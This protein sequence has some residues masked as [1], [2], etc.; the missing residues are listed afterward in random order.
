MK[1]SLTTRLSI[2]L[3]ILILASFACQT[4][5]NS[6]SR[7]TSTS[8]LGPVSTQTATST[9]EAVETQLPVQIDQPQP[10]PTLMALDLD[11]QMEI[12]EE[13]WTTVNQEYLYPDFN[14]V[15]WDEVYQRYK[16]IVESGL[17]TETFYITMDEMIWELNDEHS[18]Y[19]NPQRVAEEE[20]EYAGN[21][22]YVGIGIWVQFDPDKD[23]AVVLLT[24]P[25]SPAEAAGVKSHDVILSVEGV[26]FDD[27]EGAALDLMLGQPGTQVT[28][29]IQTPGESPREMTV[30]RA[31]ITSSIPV[32]YEALTTPG[33]RRVGYILIPTFSDSTID[34]QVGEALAA[35]TADQPLDGIILDNR[36][37]GGGWENVAAN[38]LGYFTSGVVGHFSNRAGSEPFKVPRKNVGGSADLPLVVLVGPDTVS[39]GEIV[40][41]VLKDQGR[42]VVIGETTHGNVEVLWGYNFRDGSLAWIA[43]DRFIPANNP[44]ADWEHHGIS[45]D[46]EAPGAWDEFTLA[47]DPAVEAALGYFDSN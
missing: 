35:L 37:N 23:Q 44:D 39:F 13:L 17:D 26:G 9:P 24:F 4:V 43:H 16:A 42:A 19:L 31:R 1:K 34:T 25:G 46:I 3:L 15:D 7:V 47:T 11:F 22:D 32:P 12:F 40:S 36:I 27:E 21:N 14:G 38:T 5:T 8:S 33:G 2:F 18:A 6:F 28:F 10:T 20:A 30:T 29:V 41:G 45:V